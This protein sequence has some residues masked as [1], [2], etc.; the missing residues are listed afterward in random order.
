MG[1]DLGIVKETEVAPARFHVSFCFPLLSI[2]GG[3]F[4]VLSVGQVR[5][6]EPN[7]EGPSP[8]ILNQTLP[9]PS[10]VAMFAPVGALAR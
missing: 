8:M 4:H 3:V 5:P 10:H 7:D 6:L 9:E 1:T 2:V